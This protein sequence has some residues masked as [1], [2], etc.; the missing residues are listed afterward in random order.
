MISCFS[1]NVR[2][3]WNYFIKNG[4]TKAGASGLLGNLKAESGVRSDTYEKKK[5][6]KI[7]LT[8]AQYIKKV[9]DNTYKNFVKDGAKFG[10]AQW[11]H[12]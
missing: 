7:G 4:I 10:L 12:H 1:E 6:S 9:N 3:S 8:N 2:I 5:H 11:S